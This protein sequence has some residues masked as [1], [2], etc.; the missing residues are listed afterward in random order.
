MLNDLFV[1]QVIKVCRLEDGSNCVFKFT[2]DLLAFQFVESP[3]IFAGLNHPHLCLPKHCHQ[4][5][6]SFFFL[7]P[8][9]QGTPLRIVAKQLRADTS[10]GKIRSL[11][12]QLVAAIEYLHSKDII[13]V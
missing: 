13:C 8:F 6:E 2:D 7:R 3:K 11:A 10:L 4:L 9:S 12:A 1:A 5:G